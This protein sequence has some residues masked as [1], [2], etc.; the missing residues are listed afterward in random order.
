MK[1]LV[2]TQERVVGTYIVE[3]DA[4][5]EAS[6]KLTGPPIDWT[7]VEQVEYMAYEC[8]PTKIEPIA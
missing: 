2:E 1:Y 4:P 6:K 8:A 7:G 5:D 3:A